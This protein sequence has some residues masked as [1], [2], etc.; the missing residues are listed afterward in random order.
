MFLSPPYYV[1]ISALIFC[2]CDTFL[3]LEGENATKKCCKS[4]FFSQKQNKTQ[5]KKK[6]QIGTTLEER[7]AVKAI[8]DAIVTRAARLSAAGIVAVLSQM[9]KTRDAIGKTSKTQLRAA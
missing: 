6:L 2:F 5:Q 4:K 8:T 1:S 7:R 3:D 9:G